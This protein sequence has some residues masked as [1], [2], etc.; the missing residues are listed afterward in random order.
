MRCF[1]NALSDDQSNFEISQRV[2]VRPLHVGWLLRRAIVTFSSNLSKACF[3]NPRRSKQLELPTILY[4]S[5][6]TLD[7]NRAS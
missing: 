1:D 3:N 4:D 5:H 6:V 2:G 7:D